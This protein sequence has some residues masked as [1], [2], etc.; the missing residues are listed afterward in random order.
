MKRAQNSSINPRTEVSDSKHSI[1]EVVR[2]RGEDRLRSPRNNSR[3]SIP[4]IDKVKTSGV[5]FFFLSPL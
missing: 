4:V 5:P 3:S 2:G 1:V